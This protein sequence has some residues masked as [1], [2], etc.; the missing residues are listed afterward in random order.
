MGLPTPQST[1]GIAPSKPSISLP[2]FSLLFP[3]LQAPGQSSVPQEQPSLVAQHRIKEGEMRIKSQ[4]AD[5]DYQKIK[6][7]LNSYKVKE[8]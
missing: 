7:T 3:R 8:T 2:Q 4:N 6:N 5:E 1:I